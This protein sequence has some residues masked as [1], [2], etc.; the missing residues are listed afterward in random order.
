MIIFLFGADS[1]R[2]HRFLQEMKNKF[3]KEVDSSGHSLNVIDGS[4]CD[5]QTINQQINTGSLFVR[6]RLVI[7][8]NLFKNKK[9]KIFTD[10]LQYLPS[11]AQA[12]NLIIIL[13]D[14]DLNNKKNVLKIEAK[15]LFNWLNKQKFSQEFKS[16]SAGGLLKFIQQEAG[17]YQKTIETAAANEI[18]KRTGGDLWVISKEIRKVAFMVEEE[19]ISLADIKLIANEVFSEDIFALTDAISAKNQALALKIL[20][21]QYVAGLSDEYILAMLVRQFKLLLQV[22]NYSQDNSFANLAADLKIHPFVAKKT[23]MQIKNFTAEKL[24]LYFN[25]LIN[26]DKK[27]KTGQGNIKTELTLLLTSI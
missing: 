18:I 7:I 12:D 10:L 17:L 26:L 20:E 2:A 4:T 5:L 3:I 14:E 23:W 11:I 15:K 25:S 27:N 16:L 21:E 13:K 1:F 6:K 9:T 22:K 8:E 19:K 24:L